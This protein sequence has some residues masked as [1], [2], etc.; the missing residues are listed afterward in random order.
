MK[1][2]ASFLN[3][4]SR[5]SSGPV[6]AK[7]EELAR[8]RKL[9]LLHGEGMIIGS[10]RRD[11]HSQRSSSSSPVPGYAVVA[12]DS[13]TGKEYSTMTDSKGH[14][15]IDSIPAGRF[16]L[17]PSKSAIFAE[18]KAD[19]SAFT[20]DVDPGGCSEVSLAPEE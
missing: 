12:R 5:N 13:R 19:S 18:L 10:V 16:S 6:A 3:Y 4:F 14:F 7:S 8:L 17:T 20:I 11:S 1:R 15:E 2:R 9:K